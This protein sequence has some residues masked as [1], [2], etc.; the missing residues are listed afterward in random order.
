[1]GMDSL[2]TSAFE[3]EYERLLPALKRCRREIRTLLRD[4]VGQTGGA[5]FMRARLVDSR[6]KSW[7]STLRKLTNEEGAERDAA[8]Y[9]RVSDLVGLRLVCNNLEDVY[10]IRDLIAATADL[11]IIGE[12]DYIKEPQP[13]GYRALHVT[14]EYQLLMSGGIETVLPCEIQIRTLAQDMWARLSHYDIYKNA[15]EIPA[16]ILKSSQRLSSMLAVADDIAQDNREDVSQPLVGVDDSSD[17]EITP[18]ALALIFRRAFERDPEDYLARAGVRAC[19]QAGCSRLDTLDKVLQDAS[20]RTS[21]ET[22]Y[23]EASGWPLDEESLFLLAPEVAMDAAKAS[24]IARK[25]GLEDRN[26]IEAQ[27]RTEVLSE[28]PETLDELVEEI[29]AAMSG[30]SYWEGLAYEVAREFGALNHCFCSASI[31]D[32]EAFAEGALEH[33]GLDGGDYHGELEAALGSSGFEIGTMDSSH[34]CA[35]HAYVLSKDD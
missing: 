12:Q 15:G 26:E 6:V 19:L 29:T 34:T 30:E 2:D 4:L 11:Q 24:E 23:E 31:I 17:D 5:Q 33:Y 27:A 28:L 7:P 25:R 8:I 13:N 32:P 35:Y 10:R 1:M 20:L 3:T 14:V 21:M 9:E 16:H 22:A 18:E